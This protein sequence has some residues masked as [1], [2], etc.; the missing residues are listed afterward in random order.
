MHFVGEACLGPMLCVLCVHAHMHNARLFYL[1][2]YIH[3]STNKSI[4]LPFPAQ[5]ASMGARFSSGHPSAAASPETSS[6]DPT[7]SLEELHPFPPIASKSG[8]RFYVFE[9]HHQCDQLVVCG[10]KL[11]PQIL[12]GSDYAWVSKGKAPR[13]YSDLEQ[14][15]HA[16]SKVWKNSKS[17]QIRWR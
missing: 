1:S 15:V 14:A 12:G 3:Y 8:K 5:V 11:V 6:V 10:H 2:V 7:I 4:A 16:S 17:C 13:G 9:P